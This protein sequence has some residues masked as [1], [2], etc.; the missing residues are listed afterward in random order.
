MLS[1]NSQKLDLGFIGAPM[2][3]TITSNLMP[4]LLFLYVYFIAG[5]ECWNGFTMRAFENWGPMIKLALPGFLMLE[6]EVMAFEILTLSASYLGTTALA[7]QSVLGTISSLA[8]Q[9]PFPLSIAGST[10]VANLIGATLTDSARTTARVALSFAFVIGCFNLI[11]LSLL[12]NQIPYLFTS[13]R[14]VATMVAQ[15][16]PVCASFQVVDSI[17]ANCNGILRGLGRQD[18][19]GYIQLLSY[20]VIGLPVSFVT[21]FVFGF[22]LRGTWSGIAIGL[23]VVAFLEAIYLVRCDWERSVNEAK[24]RNMTA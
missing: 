21:T 13:D 5:R 14:E 3:V 23:A 18:F 7:A 16:V 15:V 22:G 20:Y 4:L 9:I 11:V 2:A 19:G 10:R 17:A 24:S 1:D 8:F 12:R 6:S